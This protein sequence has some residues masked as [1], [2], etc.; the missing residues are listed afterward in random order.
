MAAVVEVSNDTDLPLRPDAVREFA[1]AVLG[2]EGGEGEVA[3]AFVDE[4]TMSE[5]NERYRSVDEPTDVLSFAYA[6]FDGEAWPEPE[7]PLSLPYLGDV[8]I[9]P[10][11]AALNAAEDGIA[12]EPELRRLIVHGILHLLGYDH[13]RDEGQMRAREDALLAEAA[14]TASPGLTGSDVRAERPARS[15]E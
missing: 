12:L 8:V 10:A 7:E 15:D 13:E 3:I 6:G 11:V 4:P 1:L 14:V 9:C 2:L 5:L